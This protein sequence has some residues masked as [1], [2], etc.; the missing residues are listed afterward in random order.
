MSRT[1]D[2]GSATLVNAGTDP[3]QEYLEVRHLTV[4]F[5]GFV[6]VNSV[7]LTVTSGDLRFLIGPNGAGKTTII[8]ALTALNPAPKTV[9]IIAASDGFSQHAADQGAKEAQ[10]KGD[11]SK[12]AKREKKLAEAKAELEHAKAELTQ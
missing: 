1:I 7:D 6:A 9:A 12:I 11:Q 4:S 2:P 10:A 3:R 8:D 5:D